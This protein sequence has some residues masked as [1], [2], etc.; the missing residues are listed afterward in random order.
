MIITFFQ[1]K[2]LNAWFAIPLLCL[3]IFISCT[4][5]SES[6][7]PSINYTGEE[8][9]RGIFFI[10]GEVARKIEIFKPYFAD[11]NKVNSIDRD[12]L[13]DEIVKGIKMGYPSFFDDFESVLKSKDFNK[14][15]YTLSNAGK[16]IQVVGNN[17]PKYK[18]Y[19]KMVEKVVEDIDVS[20][21]DL[22]NPNDKLKLQK[23]I[24]KKMEDN[25]EVLFSSNK[26]SRP[27]QTMFVG[28]AFIVAVALMIWEVAAA[29]NGVVMVNYIGYVNVAV[30]MNAVTS[31][32]SGGPG[33]AIAITDPDPDPFQGEPEPVDGDPNARI[34]F[35]N[36]T[37]DLFIAN[38]SDVAN[39]EEN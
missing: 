33:T 26:S 7:S 28:L 29:V 20:K 38:V 16:L 9:F 18:K 11:Q 1:K 15:Q 10:Q 30:K 12:E 4:P 5:K 36:T 35:S 6:V 32:H 21:Y 2:I 3:F 25:K 31:V 14:I 8:L 19:F 34:G 37:H 23:D 13:S 22:N 39:G 17:S 27:D 24:L